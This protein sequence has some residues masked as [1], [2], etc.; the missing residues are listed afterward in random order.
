MAV[1]E[2][3]RQL[4]DDRSDGWLAVD[5]EGF[6]GWFHD[7]RLGARPLEALGAEAAIISNFDAARVVPG[8]YR[9]DLTGFLPEGGQAHWPSGDPYDHD[10]RLAF[11]EDPGD[12][13]YLEP[14]LDGLVAIIG[15][16]SELRVLHSEGRCRG[17]VGLYRGFH[18]VCVAEVLDLGEPDYWP[19]RSRQTP[20]LCYPSYGCYGYVHPELAGIASPYGRRCVPNRPLHLDQLPRAL[21]EVVGRSVLPVCFAETPW[22]QPAE[23]TYC[24]LQ[25]QRYLSTTG[26]VFRTG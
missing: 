9:Y 25:G 6:V 18:G 19:P 12:A 21:S 20:A 15:S 7:D 4:Y 22:I 3:H 8:G 24:A 1:R 23:L 26:R 13:T 14:A 5:R 11:V 17:C 10:L 16:G 2:V